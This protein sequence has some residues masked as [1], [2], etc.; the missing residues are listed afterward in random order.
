MKSLIK[1]RAFAA[2]FFL[3]Y[4]SFFVITIFVLDI[5]RGGFGVGHLEYGYPFTYYYTSC[6]SAHFVWL[7]LVG[8]CVVAAV[9]SFGAGLITARLLAIAV[10]LWANVTSPEFRAKWYL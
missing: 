4:F 8:N 3:S 9:L 6:F 1:T 10:W 7:G 2:T 5:K